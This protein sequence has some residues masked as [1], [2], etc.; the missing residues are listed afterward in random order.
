MKITR[1]TQ[2]RI[3]E[4]STRKLDLFIAA[5]GYEKRATFIPR[6]NFYAEKKVVIGFE[7]N[8][9]NSTRKSNDK[10]YKS[11]KY[12]YL[13]TSGSEDANI[14][15]YLNDFIEQTNKADLEIAIDYSSMT[16]IWYGTIVDFFNNYI[17]SKKILLYFLYTKAT[18]SSPPK[19]ENQNYFFEPIKGFSNLSI[20]NKPTALI[21]GLGYEKRR[22]F[23]LKEYFD[24][25]E[26]YVFLTDENNTPAFHNEVCSRNQELISKLSNG[27][28]F[29]YPI[30]NLLYTRKLL[31]E[32]CKRLLMDFRIVIAPCGPKPFTL[33]SMLTASVLPNI[34]VWRISG[35]KGFDNANREP[36]GEVLCFFVEYSNETENPLML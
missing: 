9:N 34:D 2:I 16:R 15:A 31:Y 21:L 14:L 10:Y 25:D 1:S 28:I 8:R 36:D 6:M 32:L 33:I 26:V 4:L 3:D 5:S 22:A 11:S 13:H 29:K 24:A 19:I 12:D 18:F 27:Y 17:G 7:E 20:P 30:D 35:N 23:S